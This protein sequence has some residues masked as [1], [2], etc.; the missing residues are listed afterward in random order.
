[1]SRTTEEPMGMHDTARHEAS[2]IDERRYYMVT[3]IEVEKK[4][5][6]G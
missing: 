4:D 3:Q 6:S 1:M 5:T 2:Q